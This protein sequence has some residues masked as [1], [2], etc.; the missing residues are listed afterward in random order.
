MARAQ[1]YRGDPELKQVVLFDNFS[2]GMN[3]T[4]IDEQM[5]ANE[6]RYLENVELREQGRIGKRKGFKNLNIQNTEY[7]RIY[8]GLPINGDVFHIEVI[9][10]DMSNLSEYD[11]DTFKKN[12]IRHNIL[13]VTI[14]YDGGE[15]KLTQIRLKGS[16]FNDDYDI[17]VEA[18]G[19]DVLAEA[20]VYELTNR[21]SYVNITG[22]NTNH[23][24]GKTYFMMNQ[25]VTKSEDI[26]SYWIDERGYI[27]HEVHNKRNSYRPTPFELSNVGFNLFSTTPHSHTSTAQ[28][29]VESIQSVIIIDTEDDALILDRIPVSGKFR[30]RVYYTGSSMFPNELDVRFYV[31]DLS[32]ED[33]R[34]YLQANVELLSVEQVG[35]A[36]YSVVLNT[37]SKLDIN[38][39]ILKEVDIENPI[40]YEHEFSSRT[41]MVDFYLSSNKKFIKSNANGT[42]S[43]YEGGGD[44]LYSYELAKMR[45][46]Y[47]GNYIE[48]TMEDI[49]MMVY[50][51][52]Q[53]SSSDYYRSYVWLSDL[54]VA[55]AVRNK[56]KIV[57][58]D[59]SIVSP[60]HDGFLLT[61]FSRNINKNKHLYGVFGKF[62]Y[63]EVVDYTYYFR[64]QKSEVKDFGTF[65]NLK[66]TYDT[67]EFDNNINK[68]RVNRLRV[69]KVGDKYYQYNGGTVGDSDDFDEVEVELTEEVINFTVRFEVGNTIDKPIEPIKFDGLK[70]MIIKDRM[71]LFGGNTVVYS[72]MYNR[73]KD[74][75]GNTQGFTYFPNYNWFSLALGSNDSIQNIAYFR[76]SYMIFT[77]TS[78]YR[79]SGDFHTDE[80]T[81]TMVSDVVGCVSPDSIRS[82]NNTLIFLSEDGLY[83]LKQNYYLD[84]MENVSKIDSNIQGVIPY[85]ENYES[86]IYNEQYWLFIKDKDGVL[87]KVLKQYYNLDLP[88]GQHPFTIDTYNTDHF[89]VFRHGV[90]MYGLYEHEL[91]R[92]GEGYRDFVEKFEVGTG[93]EDYWNYPIKIETPYWSFGYPLHEKKF[94]NVFLKVNSVREL[95]VMFDIFVDFG[96]AISSDHFSTRVNY[97]GEVEYIFE[98][99]PSLI[100]QG[101]GELGSMNL[102]KD[103]LGDAV[104]QVHKINP[105]TKGKTIKFVFEQGSA[106]EFSVD[107]IS[108]VYK[109]GKMRESR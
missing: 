48:Q 40:N 44:S 57:R 67:F 28:T 42:V 25:I 89:Y 20:E 78:I 108:I 76:G 17:T 66:H 23:Y 86:I 14:T 62:E 4:E 8:G 104:Y 85:G 9:Q 10:D 91:F 55:S 105:A 51:G 15:V 2:G 24:D 101:V 72:D 75:S 82:M 107:A 99:R 80:F 90:D 74:S 35:Y 64:D 87:N 45:I 106:S 6:F 77:K 68:Y 61:Y 92:K 5:G 46:P 7:G 29:S 19:V 34:D 18:E 71:V 38:I 31:N 1:I 47:D 109:L 22:I 54:D 39:E 52:R 36:D 59:G 70:S 94:K 60:V 27:R 53:G 26:I 95:P 65:I 100:T 81:V 96:A 102:G 37:S 103:V 13:L 97:L 83:T 93:R 16:G 56:A 21:G 63:S 41:E 43:V 79:M 73:Q 32:K 84:G 50:E 49:P 30:V 12:K 11:Y 98:R 33:G 88:K 3:T 69:D 58:E